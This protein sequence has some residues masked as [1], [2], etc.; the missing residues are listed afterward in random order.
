MSIS[1]KEVIDTANEDVLEMI[2]DYNKQQ[3]A[4][5]HQIESEVIQYNG[6]GAVTI[7]FYLAGGSFTGVFEIEGTEYRVAGKMVG[8]GW[9][10]GVAEGTISLHVNP[11]S[12]LNS[13]T[14]LTLTAS[15]T[16]L[17]ITFY[18]SGVVVGVFTGGSG[19][20]G[21]GACAGGC[22]WTL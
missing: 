19:L 18:H 4:V 7:K 8:A 20:K 22:D 14:G 6:K 3:A 5:H 1:T 21:G 11:Q 13:D 12:L 10:T 2:Q 17:D 15:K 9:I 16:K